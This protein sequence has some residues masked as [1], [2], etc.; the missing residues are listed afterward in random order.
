MQEPQTQDI[1]RADESVGSRAL[2]GAAVAYTVLSV[3]VI[4]AAGTTPDAADTSEQVAAWF[5]AHRDAVRWSVWAVTVSTPVY[6][7]IVA[8]LRRLLPAP[9]RDVYLIG[10]ILL[11]VTTTVYEWTWAGLALH[12]DRLDPATT[13][14]LLDIAIFYGPVATGT[15]TTMIAPV[16][17]LALQG[18]VGLP[19]WLGAM[20]VVA[21][22]EQTV[23]TVTIFGSTGFT[24][25][26]GAMNWQLGG[27]LTLGWFLAFAFWGGFRGR[28]DNLVALPAVSNM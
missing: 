9:H 16:T 27:T 18:R 26:G 20:G 12:A 5:S 1:Q 7:F 3:V 10:A 13:R 14:A 15:T 11:L 28:Q 17:L 2:L 25:P 23:E 22:A 19:W 21:F 4:I 6:A 8:M 24:Q